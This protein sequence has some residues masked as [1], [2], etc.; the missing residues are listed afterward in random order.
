M[1]I[2]KT[3]GIGAAL[4]LALLAACAHAPNPAWRSEAHTALGQ[5]ESLFLR[6]ESR[7]AQTNF[8]RALKEASATGDFVQ[9]NTLHLARCALQ[10][11]VLEFT[12]CPAYHGQMSTPAQEAYLRFIRGI[13]TEED[14]ERLPAQYRKFA[15]SAAQPPAALNQVIADIAAPRSRLVAIA[16]AVERR[17]HDQGTLELAVET[18]SREGWRKPLLVYLGH[19]KRLAEQR[20]D[21]QAAQQLGERIELILD[22]LKSE[23]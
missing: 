4:A 10:T 21:K 18:A 3:Q 12:T 15:A 8:E 1:A 9:V 5:Y 23:R 11:A 19:L 14:V 13:W 7:L 16:V 2:R 17:Q 22:P 20:G 6:G